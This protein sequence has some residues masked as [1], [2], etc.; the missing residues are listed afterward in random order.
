MGGCSL[1]QPPLFSLLDSLGGRAA[2][3]QQICAYISSEG[4]K[5]PLAALYLSEELFLYNVILRRDLPCPYGF[6]Q[7]HIDIDTRFQN[8]HLR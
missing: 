6:L 3:R 1:F 2:E 4:E 8:A 5:A 7:L